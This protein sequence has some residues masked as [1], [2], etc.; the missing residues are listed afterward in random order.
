MPRKTQIIEPSHEQLIAIVAKGYN[1][2]CAGQSPDSTCSF[3]QFQ[4]LLKDTIAE[5]IKRKNK[6]GVTVQRNAKR[7]YAFSI[8]GGIVGSY[9]SYAVAAKEMD[10]PVASVITSIKRKGLYKCAYYFSFDPDFN[11]LDLPK[12]HS[13]NPLLKVQRR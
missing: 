9:D 1:E 6:E 3:H 13:R 2:Y 5:E 10:I 11:V 7:V 8:E 12:S 4:I